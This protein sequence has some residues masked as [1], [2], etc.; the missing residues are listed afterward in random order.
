MFVACQWYDD[1]FVDDILLDKFMC[2]KLDC[3]E[4]FFLIIACNS[5]FLLMLTI[6][7]HCCFSQMNQVMETAMVRLQSELEAYAKENTVREYNRCAIYLCV[8]LLP[9]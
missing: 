6:V 2:S 7:L 3:S 5:L 8:N 1:V 4:H 9:C